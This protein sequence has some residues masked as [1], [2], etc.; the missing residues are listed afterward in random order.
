M[1]FGFEILPFHIIYVIAIV[2]FF[3]GYTRKVILITNLAAMALIMIGLFGIIYGFPTV[4]GMT[5]ITY[6]NGT[7]I[8]TK[9]VENTTNFAVN[10]TALVTLMIGLAS[11]ILVNFEQWKEQHL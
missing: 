3:Y 8:L 10:T 4:T 5:E 1:S 7:S 11:L 9:T 2:L 6:V